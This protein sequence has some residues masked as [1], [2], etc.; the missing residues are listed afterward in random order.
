MFFIKKLKKRI[1]TLKKKISILI[2][3]LILTQYPIKLIHNLIHK[4]TR[5]R[6]NSSKSAI[7]FQSKDKELDID[8]GGDDEEEEEDEDGY[9]IRNNWT[10]QLYLVAGDGGVSVVAGWL[11]LTS[12]FGKA[13]E[14]R[15]VP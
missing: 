8:H 11:D 4:P 7:I 5:E 6:L 14:Q 13:A 1:Y 2:Q 10:I 3:V 12:T 9:S 15:I